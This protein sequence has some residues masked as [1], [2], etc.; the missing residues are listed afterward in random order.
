VQL[1]GKRGSRTPHL[2]LLSS[3][4]SSSSHSTSLLPTSHHLIHLHFLLSTF[5]HHGKHF[6]HEQ[7]RAKKK[8]GD[9]VETN[10]FVLTSLYHAFFFH[11]PHHQSQWSE[12]QLKDFRDIFNGFDKN[13][14]GAISAAE[15]RPLLNMVGNKVKSSELSNY[16]GQYDNDQSGHIDFDEFLALADKLTKN[17][18]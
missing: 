18:V 11:S 3:S 10:Q 6:E 5:S 17:K 8:K 4:F 14:D 2:F 16:M 13:G 1:H 7:L 9:H 12:S 15:L